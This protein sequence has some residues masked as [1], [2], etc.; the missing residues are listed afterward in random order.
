MPSKVNQE[1][2]SLKKDLDNARKDIRN[3]TIISAG[4][5]RI[6]Q[7]MKYDSVPGD[8]SSVPDG[9]ALCRVGTISSPTTRSSVHGRAFSVFPIISI[10][11]LV[12][13]KMSGDIL[14]DFNGAT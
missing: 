7:K 4:F 10:Q 11:E 1:L 3:L 8:F 12:D 5:Y 6:I 14:T 13:A 9:K 2:I